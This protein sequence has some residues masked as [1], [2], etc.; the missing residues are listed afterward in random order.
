MTTLIGFTLIS[1]DNGQKS[2]KN[3]LLED[4]TN[5]PFDLI[6]HEHYIPAIDSAMAIARN[7]ID[8][9]IANPNEPTFEN[10]I[11]ALAFAGMKLGDISS[12]LYNL[13]YAE[14]DTTLQK[15]VR[16]VAPKLTDFQNDINLNEQL[17]RKVDFVYNNIDKSALT[18]EQLTLLDKTYKGFVRRGANLNETD[19]QKYR[20]ITRQLSEI[21][22]QFE[23]NVLAETNAFYLHLTKEEEL[24][25]LPKSFVDACALAAQEKGLEGWIVTLH[26][27]SYLPFMKFSEN[28]DLR[29]KLYVAYNSRA[30]NG[31]ANDNTELIKRIVN[32]RLELANI[33]GYPNYALYVLEQRMAE[34]PSKVESFIDELLKSSIPFAKQE[35]KDVQEFAK[36]LGVDHKIEKWDWAFYTEKLKN[37]LFNF[38]EEELKPYFQLEKVTEGIFL[39][40]NKLFGITFKPISNIPVYHN[41]VTVYEVIDQDGSFLAHLYLDFFPREGKSGGA[42]MTS[43][44]SQYKQNG[45]EVR[46][47][48]S[49][50]TN[51][52]K[53]TAESPSL[54]T[55][56]EFT[57][58]LHEF[59]HA[60]HGIFANTTYPNLSGT[61]VYRDFVELP[62]QILENWAIEKEFLDQFAIHYQTGEAIPQ[63]MVQAII[64]SRNFLVGNLSIRQ[65]S[66]GLVDMAWHSINSPFTGDVLEFE[67][68]YMKQADVLP[69]VKGTAFSPGF[70]HIFGGGYAAGYYSYKWAEVL[71]ADAYSLFKENGIFCKE[72][73]QSLRENILSKGGSEHPMVLYKR[74]RGHEPS[75]DA[76]LERS[77][78]K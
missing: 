22:L 33:L 67:Q 26:M 8:S 78:M 68:K 20:E 15:I 16:D 47:L 58:F 6:K 48:I 70:S 50:V 77:G 71:D 61:S 38:N 66:F 46:P 31:N 63:E 62:S 65:L 25:G 19:K 14:T 41:D 7:E 10:T 56:Y 24:I 51:F 13:N 1:C 23:E 40:S 29:E 34:S 59:G 30:F 35:L 55:F 64:D 52:T 43:Y 72:T 44:R 5:P 18:P 21:G 76:L 49:V 32:L 28:R 36:S 53:P 11:E 42:W 60:L 54:L 73:A 3:P 12:I 69:T 57:T 9:I 75:T 4:F 74:F 37:K 17:F 27:P 2:N 45:N 39:L